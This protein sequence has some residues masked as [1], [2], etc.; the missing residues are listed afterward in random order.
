MNNLKSML[1][2]SSTSVN[3]SNSQ[4]D[5]AFEDLS[6]D[7]FFADVIKAA[8]TS[9]S[10]NYP[11]TSSIHW[12]TDVNTFRLGASFALQWFSDKIQNV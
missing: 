9:A 4:S 6:V 8:N 1:S 5:E 2:K 12:K 7:V 3:P 10:E 11:D